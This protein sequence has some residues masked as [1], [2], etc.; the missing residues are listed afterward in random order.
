MLADTV[1]FAEQK[2]P[3]TAVEE[4]EVIRHHLIE[5][6]TNMCRRQPNKAIRRILAFTGHI[7]KWHPEQLTLAEYSAF[8]VRDVLAHIELAATAKVKE[9]P[10]KDNRDASQLA[11]S[12]IDSDSRDARAK[13]RE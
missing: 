13:Q 7:C 8:V 11:E 10:K 1:L 2:E 9:A 6:F 5:G 4:G 12:D 3:M